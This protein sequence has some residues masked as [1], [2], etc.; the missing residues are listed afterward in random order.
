MI[1]PR[2][3]GLAGGILWGLSL[4]IMTIISMYT[5]YSQ[6]FLTLFEGIYPWYSISWPGSFSGLISGFVDG[7]I[8]LYLLAWLYNKV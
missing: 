5:G 3:L 2:K 4:F 7:F 6:M 1:N 8:G